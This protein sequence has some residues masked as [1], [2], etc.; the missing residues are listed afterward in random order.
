MDAIPLRVTLD[1]A[2]NLF[3][4][5]NQ[6]GKYGYGTVFKLALTSGSNP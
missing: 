4:T 1:A 6:G 3:G 2:G 5:T